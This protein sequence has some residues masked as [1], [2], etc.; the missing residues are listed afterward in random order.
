MSA[1][2][3]AITALGLTV[4]SETG[5][6][7]QLLLIA[8]AA[9]WRRPVVAVGGVLGIT[10]VQLPAVA[11]GGLLSSRA[12]GQLATTIA[13]VVGIVFVVLG[14]VALASARAPEQAE[15][16]DEALVNERRS[17][18]W[19]STVGLTAGLL[20][21]AELGDKTMF[22]TA[23]LSAVR[24]PVAVL[25]GASAASVCDPGHDRRADRWR[26]RRPGARTRSR[27]LPEAAF[28]VTGVVTII[29]A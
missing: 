23:A 29:T 28:L 9:R 16:D 14:L 2:G 3:D 22:T 15:P 19:L 17:A 27:C 6:K 7:S 20:F 1:F 18:S 11:A 5:D 25:V 8:L 4:L 26:L 12:D 24:S 21:A 10:G 13:V